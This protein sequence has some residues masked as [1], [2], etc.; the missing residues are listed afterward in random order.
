MCI[1]LNTKRREIKEQRKIK[2]APV[3]AGALRSRGSDNFG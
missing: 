1:E 2:V 3:I